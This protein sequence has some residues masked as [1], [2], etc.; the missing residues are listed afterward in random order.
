MQLLQGGTQS[1][2]RKCDNFIIAVSELG[3]SVYR[4]DTN[5][6]LGYCLLTGTVS[7]DIHHTGVYIC[8]T[9]EIYFLP[10][11]SLSG[12]SPK[13]VITISSYSFDNLDKFMITEI[14]NV[15]GKV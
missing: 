3:V 5:I 1:E 10:I 4:L 12:D 6:S 8:S 15:I 13:L 11:N 2:L 14:K 9:S 7:A